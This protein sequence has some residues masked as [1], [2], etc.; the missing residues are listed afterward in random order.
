RRPGLASRADA[1][2]YAGSSGVP[3]QGSATSPLAVARGQT[4][5]RRGILIR[6]VFPTP[7]AG[8]R[9]LLYLD[10]RPHTL[11]QA[12]HYHRHSRS[13][14]MARKIL[15]RKEMRNDYDAA[16]RRKEEE[17]EVEEASDEAED[18]EEE[19]GA[20]DEEEPSDEEEAEVE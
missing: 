8:T 3:A 14:F 4:G 16:E 19:E 6:R 11:S 17:V 1:G 10:F 2:C 15:N 5:R 7:S 20:G 13:M 18:E 9:S 12:T